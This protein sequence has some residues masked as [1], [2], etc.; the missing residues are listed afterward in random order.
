M[1]QNEIQNR[2][3]SWL[4]AYKL[5]ERST[6]CFLGTFPISAKDQSPSIGNKGTEG[7]ASHQF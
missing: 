6:F 3:K 7:S 1:C 4:R 2:K 5:D